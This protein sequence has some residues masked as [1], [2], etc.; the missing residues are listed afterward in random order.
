[1]G[2]H[3]QSDSLRRAPI[4]NISCR[5]RDWNALG[6]E[7]ILFVPRCVISR[8]SCPPKRRWGTHFR[9][10]S[11]NHG[12]P[13]SRL[14]SHRL[15]GSRRPDPRLQGRGSRRRRRHRPA[16]RPPHEDGARR[17]VPP[18]HISPKP[19]GDRWAIRPD[20][21]DPELTLLPFPPPQNPL[22]TELSLYDIAGTPGV[23]ADVSH[24]NTGAQVKVRARARRSEIRRQEVVGPRQT[25]ARRPPGVTKRARRAREVA[26]CTR[27]ATPSP[28]T[29][30]ARGIHAGAAATAP[31]TPAI[32]RHR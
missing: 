31:D 5:K 16:L 2:N 13:P 25:S 27:D 26:R 29:R 21:A 6:F 10:R 30:I 12:C 19:S 9:S 18:F 32:T 11:Y 3:N 7:Y 1:M 4:K 8:R 14:L 20:L 15:Q 23:A 22:V 24:V 17:D 28:R